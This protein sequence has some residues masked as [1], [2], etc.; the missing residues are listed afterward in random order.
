MAGKEPWTLPLGLCGR[1]SL[2]KE[3]KAA[4]RFSSPPDWSACIVSSQSPRSYQRH[5]LP[6]HRALQYG[7]D[8][9]GHLHLGFSH[10]SVHTPYLGHLLPC[11][12]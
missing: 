11:R 10:F 9:R 5:S 4:A 8:L 3:G 7:R 12:L 2:L 6:P 1:R